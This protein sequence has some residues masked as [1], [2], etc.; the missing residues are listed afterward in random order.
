MANNKETKSLYLG[1]R[2]NEVGGDR[3]NPSDRW[4]ARSDRYLNPTII[5]FSDERE[6]DYSEYES[7]EISDEMHSAEKIYA[8]V[9]TY[10]DGNTFGRT[11]GYLCLDSAFIDEDL[12][13]K[14][15]KDISEG[16]TDGSI[17]EPWMGY[18]SGLEE[19]E[20]YTV[21]WEKE[22]TCFCNKS[23]IH[24]KIL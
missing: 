2:N 6:G 17:Y 20:V 11:Y 9:V 3:Y 4:S 7:L 24:K 23:R 8:V 22:K 14:R 21:K 19:V 18:F 1:Y 16:K 10:R 5:G 15:A 12:A 13:M